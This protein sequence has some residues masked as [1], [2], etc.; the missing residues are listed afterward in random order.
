ME[1]YS[2]RRGSYGKVKK[3]FFIFSKRDKQ[4]PTRED[5]VDEP[6]WGVTGQMVEQARRA[7]M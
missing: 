1:S 7:G 4:V 2:E 3:L 6:I 5:K